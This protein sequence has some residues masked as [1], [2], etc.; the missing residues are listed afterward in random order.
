MIPPTTDGTMMAA[1]R[2]DSV[3]KCG[4]GEVAVSFWAKEGIETEIIG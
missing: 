2:S 3:R 4:D 1:S